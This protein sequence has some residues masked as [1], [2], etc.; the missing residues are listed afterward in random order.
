MATWL[1]IALGVLASILLGI[2]IIGI[3]GT[4]FSD[5]DDSSLPPGV[6]QD[7]LDMLNDP[8]VLDELLE[9]IF[10]DLETPTPKPQDDDSVLDNL[11]KTNP[12]FLDLLEESFILSYITSPGECR[13]G[14]RVEGKCV[15]EVIE[16]EI[17]EDP[18]RFA[19]MSDREIS[20]FT[21]E[22]FVDHFTKLTECF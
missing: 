19:E 11:F 14:C 21:G 16:D 5:D 10:E 6:N 18:D 20:T 4:I 17:L 13:L 1:K 2:T 22:F 15:W 8:E 3:V 9:G 7:I 12:E